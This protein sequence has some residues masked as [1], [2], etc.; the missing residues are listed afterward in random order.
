MFT[1][2]LVFSTVK[3]P[4]L[5]ACVVGLV[6]VACLVALGGYCIHRVIRHRRLGS[7]LHLFA[8]L[9]REHRLDVRDIGELRRVAARHDLAQPGDLFVDPRWLDAVIADPGGD[10]DPQRLAALRK[11]LFFQGPAGEDAEREREGE[12]DG[13]DLCDVASEPSRV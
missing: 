12:E 13:I 8:D 10:F 1:T 5:M 3:Q 2:R 6:A 7:H 9:C 4:S 11:R